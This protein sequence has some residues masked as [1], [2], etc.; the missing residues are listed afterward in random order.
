MQ[1]D[2]D[3]FSNNSKKDDLWSQNMN[4]DGWRLEQ[5]III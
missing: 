3:D 2:K 1:W 4:P 5:K